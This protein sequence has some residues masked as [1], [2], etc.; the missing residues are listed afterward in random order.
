MSTETSSGNRVSQEMEEL[1][2]QLDSAL[3][4]LARV[5][6]A[7]QESIPFEVVRRLSD[8]AI[9]TLVWRE[10]RGLSEQ[11]LA[12]ASG[13]PADVL[14]QIEGG[15]EDVPIRVMHEIARALKVDLDD[16]VPWDVS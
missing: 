8:G 9:P 16:L 5:E 11:E 12:I 2:D 13:V 7:N 6:Q 3:L 15:K 14:M 1:E 10:Y 4:Q